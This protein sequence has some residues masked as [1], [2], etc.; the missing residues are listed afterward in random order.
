M[1]VKRY[2]LLSYEYW[3]TLEQSPRND[4]RL[5]LAKSMSE[6]VVKL[7]DSIPGIVKGSVQCKN[8]DVME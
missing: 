1:E 8:I 6:A 7:H 4:V 5:V 3:V 2:F